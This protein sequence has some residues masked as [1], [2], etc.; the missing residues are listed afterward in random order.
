[1]SGALQCAPHFVDSGFQSHSWSGP[2][3]AAGCVGRDGGGGSVGDGGA[4]GVVHPMMDTSA[5]PRSRATQNRQRRELT[6]SRAEHNV[7]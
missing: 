1:M 5:S 3:R 6:P 4:S 7:F 2:G